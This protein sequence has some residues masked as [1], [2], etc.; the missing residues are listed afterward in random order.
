[1]GKTTGLQAMIADAQLFDVQRETFDAL[2]MKTNYNCD[3]YT[4]QCDGPRCDCVCQQSC[5]AGPCHSGCD[6]PSSY[7]YK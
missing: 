2:N 5:D 1:M 7:K 6:A 4:C 3:C